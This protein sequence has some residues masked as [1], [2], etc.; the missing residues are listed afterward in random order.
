[1][2]EC[3]WPLK[4]GE[5][6]ARAHHKAVDVEERVACCAPLEVEPFER[7]RLADEFGNAS[8]RRAAAKEKKS[9]GR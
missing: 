6:I 1:M 8:R 2:I 7:H 4:I 3:E 9:S 5:V